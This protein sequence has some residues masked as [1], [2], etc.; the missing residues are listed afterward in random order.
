VEKLTR[1]ELTLQQCVEWGSKIFDFIFQKSIR[2][3]LRQILAE[4][5][6]L[7]ITIATS[8]PELVFIPWEL[9]C[10]TLPGLLPRFLCFDQHVHLAR[11]LRLYNRND[12]SEKALGDGKNLRIL[13]VTSNPISNSYIDVMKEE[14]MLRF[15]VD[16][17]PALEGVQLEVLHDANVNS[18]RD[19]LL[20]FNPHI[21]HLACHEGYDQRQGLGY[22][23]L[24]S[25]RDPNVI[26]AVNS[27]RFSAL[28]Q[29]PGSVRLAFANTCYGAY[30]ESSTAFSGI[31]QCLHAVG[32]QEVV[33][34]QFAL[35]DATAHAIV[36]NFY[37]HLLRD[38]KSVEK[39]VTQVRRHLFINGYLHPE[40]FGLAM[41]QGNETYVWEGHAPA[42]RIPEDDSRGFNEIHDFFEEELQKRVVDRL[43]AEFE[44]NR[45]AL[46]DLDSLAAED[47]LLMHKVFDSLHVALQIT[48][49]MTSSGIDA[50]IFLRV[51]S[52]AK[53]LA[54]HR[55]EKQFV[56]TAIIVM[57]AK[58]FDTYLEKFELTKNDALAWHQ[59]EVSVKQI[60]SVA[61][62]A[63]GEDQAMF[64]VLYPDDDM[65]VF[66]EPLQAKESIT[67]SPLGIDHKWSRLCASVRDFGVA[68]IL[69]GDARVKVILQG[70]Q[71]AEFSGGT[72]RHSNLK[73]VK[74]GFLRLAESESL[75]K[76][77]CLSILN[78]S[79]LASERR[80]GLSLM[81]QREQ[82]VRL[83]PGFFDV[84]KR[85][86]IGLRDK[87]IN[88]V[89]DK[90]FLDN[91]AGD[92]SVVITSDGLVI[93]FNAAL[94]YSEDTEIDP[95][96]GT[97][98]R[99]LSAQKVTK[100]TD[101]IAFVV[102]EDGP[103]SIF[104]N[105]ELFSSML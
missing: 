37:K 57:H 10:D 65:K 52:L 32:V 61:I 68:F 93:A 19:R 48:K 86:D 7:R 50:G 47:I 56:S 79:L 38:G 94:S 5:Q 34:L 8:V 97:G 25:T 11:S 35:Q 102:S 81:L 75:N 84:R 78:K 9:M 55:V 18:L 2:D 100:E 92:N 88:E 82:E 101:A 77:V 62:K 105:G 60:A 89:D 1:N 99:H 4:K 41:Y 39:S 64:V 71:V 22:V 95:I 12:V 76:E 96:P 53:V 29:E 67:S 33:A 73:D 63:S 14:N 40:T 6:Q 31:A 98:S 15:V 27:Y 87:P 58:D 104:L 23:A 103:L 36:L 24:E 16:E 26:D 28:I 21:V 17:A 49:A 69:P 91:V 54:L 70:E 83:H 59:F 13:L 66:I 30:Q 74:D 43:S 3:R 85:N 90:L 42:A 46:K 51:L 20:V 45:E 80:R 72:W 44:R